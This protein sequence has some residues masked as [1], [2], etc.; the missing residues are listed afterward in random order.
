MFVPQSRSSRHNIQCERIV[1]KNVK[2]HTA[3]PCTIEE[4]SPILKN[5]KVEPEIDR[6]VELEVMVSLRVVIGNPVTKG[7]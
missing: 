4:V 2:H 1:A 3:E 6:E 7:K 5:V